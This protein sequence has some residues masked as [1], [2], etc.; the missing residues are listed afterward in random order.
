M[1]F[2]TELPESELLEIFRKAGCSYSDEEF[3]QVFLR[4][5]EG[6]KS[7]GRVSISSLQE[8]ISRAEA[9]KLAKIHNGNL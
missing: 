3:E 5:N 9:E 6:E 7:G 8:A 1:A 4:A 2:S